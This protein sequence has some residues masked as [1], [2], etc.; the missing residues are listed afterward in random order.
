MLMAAQTLFMLTNFSND[1]TAHR[2]VPIVMSFS[3]LFLVC[4][5]E[6]DTSLST[7]S[8]FIRFFAQT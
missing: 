5:K 7:K 2:I 3:N 8:D 1:T 4:A 6:K